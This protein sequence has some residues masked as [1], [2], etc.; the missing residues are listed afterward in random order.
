MDPAALFHTG[1]GK[2]GELKWDLKR[3]R[4]KEKAK[5]KGKGRKGGEANWSR[6]ENSRKEGFD[7]NKR[8]RTKEPGGVGVGGQQVGDLKYG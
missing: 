5:R 4:E 3:K 2:E 6:V 1:G 7:R 8:E